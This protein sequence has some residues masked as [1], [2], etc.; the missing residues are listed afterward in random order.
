[1]KKKTRNMIGVIAAILSIIAIIPSMR[2]SIVEW[3]TDKKPL[4]VESLDYIGASAEFLSVLTEAEVSNG[5]YQNSIHEIV[6]SP[7]GYIELYIKNQNNR[8]EVSIKKDLPIRILSYK[9]LDDNYFV[10][11]LTPNFGGKGGGVQE[12]QYFHATIGTELGSTNYAYFIDDIKTFRES[13]G[14]V[15]DS[16]SINYDTEYY[17]LYPG[18][19]ELFH[20]ITLFTT[21]GEY[22]FQIGLE[23]YEDNGQLKTIWADKIFT[24][25]ILNNLH[26]WKKLSNVHSSKDADNIIE[27]V[28]NCT[29]LDSSSTGLFFSHYSCY[30]VDPIFDNK[31]LLDESIFKSCSDELQT[32]LS[33]GSHAKSCF[34]H[35]SLCLYSEPNI[36]SIG[37]EKKTF[38]FGGDLTI[39]DGPVCEFPDYPWWKVMTEGGDIGW[40]PEK[41][42]MS[43]EIYS[44]CPSE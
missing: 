21:P 15:S 1:M 4:I 34:D 42:I 32:R 2:E 10:D 38:L 19:V 17:V 35:T 23:M 30:A 33:V 22:R 14:L 31:H 43:E 44:L 26:I 37:S 5:L 12:V 24:I 36:L 9:K 29:F 39:I 28:A 27:E 41:T 25:K 11:A 40:A 8:S 18:D 20:V 3:I 13:K 16:S 6:D 7:E